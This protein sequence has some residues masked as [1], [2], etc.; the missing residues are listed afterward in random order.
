MIPDSNETHGRKEAAELERQLSFVVA[1]QILVRCASAESLSQDSRL[2]ETPMSSESRMSASKSFTL[3]MEK[4]IL[5][6]NFEFEDV[7]G[8]QFCSDSSATKCDRDASTTSQCGASVTGCDQSVQSC[9]IGVTRCDD[10]VQSCD[11]VVTE[12]DEPTGVLRRCSTKRYALVR[13][14]KV[15]GDVKQRRRG[16][17]EKTVDE[18]PE[19]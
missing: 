11:K 16:I 12:C 3:E 10:H 17:G 19:S 13:Q 14:S 4:K 5:A 6:R 18:K 15:V 1:K 9:D 2:A 8:N 7:I